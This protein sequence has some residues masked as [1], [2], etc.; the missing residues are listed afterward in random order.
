M[1][2]TEGLPVGENLLGGHVTVVPAQLSD[3]VVGRPERQYMVHYLRLLLED[4]KSHL[5]VRVVLLTPPP[6]TYVKCL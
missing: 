6:N 2:S 1:F 5:V 4:G 3:Q